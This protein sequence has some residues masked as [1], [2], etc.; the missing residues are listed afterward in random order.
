[1][2]LTVWLVRWMSPASPGY[3]LQSPSCKVV[4]GLPS[5]ASSHGPP[6]NIRDSHL[7]LTGMKV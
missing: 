7:P 1:M 6:V 2:V 5:A 4:W 3:L